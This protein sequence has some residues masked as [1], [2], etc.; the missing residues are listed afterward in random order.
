MAKIAL[1][2]V[3]VSMIMIHSAQVVVS[4]NE[5]SAA[6]IADVVAVAGPVSGSESSPALAPAPTPETTTKGREINL[7]VLTDVQDM[8]LLTGLEDVG[9]EESIKNVENSNVE[10]YL[11]SSTK[12]EVITSIVGKGAFGEVD[13]EVTF[14]RVLLD[15]IEE[16]IGPKCDYCCEVIVDSDSGKPDNS[17]TKVE[18]LDNGSFNRQHIHSTGTFVP[19]SV[20]SAS[21]KNDLLEVNKRDDLRVMTS[22]S[23]MLEENIGLVNRDEVY[24]CSFSD[25]A[26]AYGLRVGGNDLDLGPIVHEGVVES[27]GVVSPITSGPICDLPRVNAAETIELNGRQRKIRL[28]SDVLMNNTTLFDKVA[29]R[30]G[31]EKTFGA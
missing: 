11:L 16:A 2:I 9:Q 29:Q 27:K 6:P 18:S 10:L 8:G 21:V 25:F 12:V 22:M 30:I 28:V 26:E 15:K 13:W 1:F 23:D 17:N 3:L 24:H 7:R 14:S 19:N 31:E 20:K 5:P 4:D